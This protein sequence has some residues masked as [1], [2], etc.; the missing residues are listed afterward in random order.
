M[1]TIIFAF[2][3]LLLN[4]GGFVP[5]VISQ[6]SLGATLLLFFRS[7]PRS[8]VPQQKLLSVQIGPEWIILGMEFIIATSANS[9]Q[10]SFEVSLVGICPLAAFEWARKCFFP[11]GPLSGALHD[12]EPK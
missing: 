5:F 1:F 3:L 8:S 11:F 4:D 2:L 6:L 12:I 9:E 10:M 7:E